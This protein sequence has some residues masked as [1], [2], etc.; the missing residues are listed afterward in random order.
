MKATHL[1]VSG[2]FGL[3]S[4]SAFAHSDSGAAH[5]A[6]HEDLRA[7]AAE[8]SNLAHDRNEAT[9]AAERAR[10]VRRRHDELAARGD[11]RGAHRLERVSQHQANVAR[12]A[13]RQVSHDR[14]VIAI[15]HRQIDHNRNL[16]AIDRN[17]RA[18]AGY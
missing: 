14:N 3:L 11:D 15:K 17:E 2:L 18:R 4:V 13:R 9:I 8:K 10:A 5:R 1:L 7:I 6:I 12:I 16:I